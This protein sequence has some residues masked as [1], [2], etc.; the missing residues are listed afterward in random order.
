LTVLLEAK[1]N[2]AQEFLAR[3]KLPAYQVQEV[4][5]VKM[6][7]FVHPGDTLVSQLRLKQ[8]NPEQC[9]LSFRSEVEGQRVCLLEVVMHPH[10]H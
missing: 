3:S 1:L 7:D 8:H 5:K 4:R 9:I 6:N 10:D 2:L